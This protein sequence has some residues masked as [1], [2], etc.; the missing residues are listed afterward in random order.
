MIYLKK[1]WKEPK[2]RGEKTTSKK[3]CPPAGRKLQTSKPIQKPNQT[4][5]KTNQHV[6]G[7]MLEI[8]PDVNSISISFLDDMRI[9]ELKMKIL[10]ITDGLGGGGAGEGPG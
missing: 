9:N 3:L 4:S 6:K 2:E 5:Q 10:Y 1:P 8:L 7:K